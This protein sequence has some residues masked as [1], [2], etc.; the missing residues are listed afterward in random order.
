[1]IKSVF[2]GSKEKQG[3]FLLSPYIIL[4]YNIENSNGKANDDEVEDEE[5]WISRRL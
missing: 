1:M 4:N 2:W 5:G 3:S